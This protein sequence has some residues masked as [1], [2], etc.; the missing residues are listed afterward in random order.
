M[1]SCQG[2]QVHC[3]SYAQIT[4][5]ILAAPTL[6]SLLSGNEQLTASWAGVTD[7]GGYKV[8]W[9]SGTQEY[10]TSRQRT[11]TS[12]QTTQVITGL[13]NGTTYTV[14]VIATATGT[15]DSAPSAELTAVPR[16]PAPTLWGS[17]TVDGAVTLI[18]NSQQGA[19][20]GYRI[21]WKESTTSGWSGA[22]SR[23]ITSSNPEIFE[24][25]SGLT[26]A[27]SYD[28]RA[29]TTRN[30]ED[31]NWSDV[32]TVAGKP[33]SPA[34]LTATQAPGG[35]ALSWTP[36]TETGGAS[37]T[38]Y[39]VQFREDADG[40]W[41]DNPA[42]GN[43]YP[44]GDA[45][46]F[47]VTTVHGLQN[48]VTY[49]F[50]IRASNVARSSFFHPNDGSVEAA[51]AIS[52]DVPV[53]VMARVTMD[54]DIDW[55]WEAPP[56][57]SYRD[58]FHQT[59]LSTET[60]WQTAVHTRSTSHTTSGQTGRTYHFR[61]RACTGATNDDSV[62]GGWVPAQ[63]TTANAGPDAPTLTATAGADGEISLSWN[64]PHDGGNPITGYRVEYKE[65]SLAWSAALSEDLTSTARSH[66]VT[67]LNVGIAVDVRVRAVN[68]TD[69]GAWSN[70]ETVGGKPNS[71]QN[72]GA[73]A[74]ASA[75]SVEVFWDFPSATGGVGL[76]GYTINWRPHHATANWSDNG[77]TGTKHVGPTATSAHITAADG[78]APNT[79]YNFRISATNADRRSFWTPGDGSVAAMTANIGATI[80]STNPTT[81]KEGNLHGAEL[82]VDLFGA[83][84]VQNLDLSHFSFSPRVAGLTFS[85]VDRVDDDTAV[86]TLAYAWTDAAMTSDTNLAVLLVTSATSH[87]AA[88]T[89]NTVTVD[90]FVSTE[91][92]V[93]AGSRTLSVDEGDNAVITVE[94]TEPVPIAF[95]ADWSLVLGTASSDDTDMPTSGEVT[96]NAGQTTAT[97][98]VSTTEDALDESNEIFGVLVSV[99]STASDFPAALMGKVFLAGLGST[100][101]ITITDDDA[102]AGGPT[103]LTAT[104]SGASISLFWS[105]PS[106]RG[107]LNGQTPTIT[108]Y[109][110]RTSPSSTGVLLAAWV[111][112]GS[113]QSFHTVQVNTAGDHYFQ[114]QAITGV[115][116]ANGQPAGLFSNVAS[117]MVTIAA[118]ISATDPPTLTERT[119]DG[120][121]LT[122]DL[123]GTTYVSSLSPGQF[124]LQPATSGLSVASVQR[125]S[126][127]RAV[128]TLAFSGNFGSDLGLSVAVDGAANAAGAPLTTGTVTVTQAPRPDQV[129]NVRLTPGPGSLDVTWNAASNSDGYVV[130]WKLSSAAGYDNANQ[131]AVSGGSTTRA[132]LGDLLGET[133]YDVRV[134]ATSRFASNGP[135][136]LTVSET[137]LPAHAIISA[138]D[139]SPLTEYNLGGA[140]LTVEFLGRPYRA[141]QPELLVSQF[142]A[143]GVPGVSVSGVERLSDRQAQI[144]FDYDAADP[145]TDFDTDATLLIR[146]D[147][148]AFNWGYPITAVTT[149]QAVVEPPPAQV[150]NVRATGGT[151]AVQVRWDA[152]P[153]A[154]ENADARPYKVQW[155]P[156]DRGWFSE[157][158][159]RGSQTMYTVGAAPGTEYTVR[160]I[161]TNNRA[162]D[163]QPSAEARATTREFRYRVA[164]TEPTPLTGVNLNGA[165][166][167]IDME[168]A[169]WEPWIGGTSHRHR[170]GLSGLDMNV[171]V[172]R[173]ERVSDSRLKVFLACR[174]AAITQDGTLTLTIYHDLH[175]WNQ[176]V[177]VTVPVQAPEQAGG[178]HVVETTDT[179]ITVA[180]DRVEGNDIW[181]QVRWQETGSLYGWHVRGMKGWSRPDQ[182]PSY[183]I[184]DLTPTT[185]YT[186]QVRFYD[187]GGAGI[188][189]WSNEVT[190]TTLGATSPA[191]RGSVT[192]TAADPLAITEGGSSTYTV[193][194]D[195]EPTGNVVITMSSDNADV[196]TQPSSLTFTTGNWQTAQTV[197]ISAAHDGDAANDAATI[198]HTVSGADGYAGIAV[199]SVNVSVADD[200]AAGVTVS[201]TSLDL[202][203][204]GSAT[205]TVVLHTQPV[206]D[207]GIS[208]FAYGGVTAQPDRLTFTPDNWNT[209]QTVTV[210][211]A[212]DDNTE[213][214]QVFI[215]HGIDAAAESAYATLL[216]PSVTVNVTDDDTT[217]E[218]AQ[219]DVPGLTVSATDP[220][221]V[222]E[223]GSASY[224]VSLDAQPAENVVVELST[225]NPDLIA[226]PASLTF[227]AHNWQTP[228]TVT[229][230]ALQDDDKADEQAIVAHRVRGETAA[231]VNVS[232]TDDDGDRAVLEAFYNATGGASWTN[233]A[234]WLS[235][236]P[237]SEWHGVTVNGQGQV[238]QLNLRDN[239]LSG[240]LPAALGKLEALQVL[241]LDRNNLTGSL[242]AELGN[243]R[244]LTRL[245]LN[246]NSLTGAIPSGL[247]SLSNLSIIGL[248]R[249]QLSGDLPSSL[250]NLGG[251]TRLSLHDN[252]GL[253]GALP[254]GFADIDGLQRL[255]IANT[256]I[257]IPSGQAFSDWLAGVPDVP[258][259]DDL[260]TC[261]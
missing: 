74:S 100:S 230:S 158:M 206:S 216:V 125:V 245:A 65:S 55:S 116:G 53:N 118:N 7:A 179:S 254:S 153:G 11:T 113:G 44:G 241:S 223:G 8:Q 148:S 252:T 233:N 38:G 24:D 255:A 257:C 192:V 14:R 170:V 249:N 184:S 140:R 85:S 31:S 19:R 81:L 261:E 71:P 154:N 36:P 207:V 202:Q 3:G 203:E 226:Q 156:S 183:R 149:V 91:V 10:D 106:D 173:L 79:N 96:F 1:R 155:M 76:T 175:T 177:V 186:V 232:V 63:A 117:A 114:V 234:N 67:N 130:Q 92:S 101:D 83:T 142:T 251:L 69:N 167:I 187:E 21:E 50:R 219:V 198:S 54:Q 228:Q 9:K 119:L 161:A 141:W 231:S 211:A 47:T 204:G 244:N 77:P 200:E 39:H 126:N 195:G 164:G 6:N 30:G 18:V 176:D 4:Y 122:V 215:N 168:G 227:T 109:R 147:G 73:T 242:P 191:S 193:V 139:P 68:P 34:D 212:Q 88:L 188:G 60:N 105:P 205:Y 56:D 160:V 213:N 89:T 214:E 133:G 86:L 124:S 33:G 61:V 120:T 150:Q 128:L 23:D 247:G 15:A 22:M 48:G 196:T 51:T 45:T 108:G 20:T 182:T 70:V 127:T 169:V 136:S 243:L 209:P 180:W 199:A 64:E 35:I 62:C 131:R 58:Y 258:G 151:Q 90:D 99:I 137:T 103:G 144:T 208:P 40:N 260:A 134:Y 32:F 201:E 246:R 229:L 235:D 217:A 41:N 253:S 95:N 75:V 98:P 13:T 2:L 26:V 171:W 28:F 123:V 132:T 97:I 135:I 84:Y 66:N 115:V 43:A 110:Y 102:A 5:I 59:R 107:M 93:V 162:P 111:E 27:A 82:T 194:L 165:A 221:S 218:P 112:T 210:S 256:G 57:T 80:S 129:R 236:K 46:S 78:L 239:N 178:L 16:P 248:A 240:S 220:L 72:F 222:R 259:R 250:G 238:T 174:G 37:L 152:V 146:V 12:T 166:V 237:L 52:D 190:A 197:T 42:T 138:T 104:A 172:E 49:N 189:R 25:I 224:T 143:S 159:V 121:R 29:R 17:A 163:G 225:N 145:A 181:Y 185:A 157:R 87:T 94:L